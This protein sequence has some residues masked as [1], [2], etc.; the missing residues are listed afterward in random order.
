MLDN[1]GFDDPPLVVAKFEDDV[2]DDTFVRDLEPHS[3]AWPIQGFAG[4]ESESG[5]GQGR[6]TNRL[7]ADFK[8]GRTF[9]ERSRSVHGQGEVGGDLGVQVGHDFWMVHDVLSQDLLNH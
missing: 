5:L 8:G 4:R 6:D 2:A 3:H 9:G 1:F 7:A